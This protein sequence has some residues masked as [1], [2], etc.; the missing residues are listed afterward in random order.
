MIQVKFINHSGIPIS[1]GMKNR[2]ARNIKNLCNNLVDRQEILNVSLMIKMNK[3][4]KFEITAKTSGKFSVH[5][6]LSENKI[7]TALHKIAKVL[8]KKIKSINKKNVR[9]S[10]SIAYMPEELQEDN[11]LD[12]MYL[13]SNYY[14]SE[15]YSPDEDFD[16]DEDFDEISQLRSK[17]NKEWGHNKDRDSWNEFFSK[18][19]NNNDF[20][21][22]F[23]SKE[24]NNNDFGEVNFI[25]KEDKACCG[26]ANCDC[27]KTIGNDE[28]MGNYT[29]NNEEEFSKIPES[30]YAD[31]NNGSIPLLVKEEEMHPREMSLQDA[32]QNFSN[33]HD[34]K[35]PMLFKN[36]GNQ[37][38]SM[39]YQKSD[40]VIGWMEPG[41]D[42]D[43]HY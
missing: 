27:N 13:Q 43:Y 24:A 32:V 25:M 23:F 16:V 5:T 11:L 2:S 36:K 21:N 41:S 17:I 15:Q 39:L 34:H 10:S 31:D 22:E 1:S 7:S 9:D 26:E 38:L 12:Q 40:K 33:K 19:A 20:G 14:D 29:W 18:E 6:S 37:N 3:S 35:R 30:F 8:I 42:S 28:Q 4:A